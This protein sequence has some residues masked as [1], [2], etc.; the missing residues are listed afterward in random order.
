MCFQP[1]QNLQAL[2]LLFKEKISVHMYIHVLLT[3]W[4]NGLHRFLFYDDLLG[5]MHPKDT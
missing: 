2:R 3:V 1:Y 5:Q 4:L